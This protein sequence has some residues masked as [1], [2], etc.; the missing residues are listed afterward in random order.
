MPGI[1]QH[2]RRLDITVHQSGRMG[3][4]QSRSHRRHQRHHP[5]RRQRARAAHQR[6]HVPAGHV[7]HCDEQHPIG[8]AG[9]MHRD[10]V[11]VIDRRGRPRLAQEPLPE[12]LISRQCRRQD[13]QRHPPAQPLITR[14]EH[15]RHPT[16]ADL[17]FQPVP[18]HLR[19]RAKP[20]QRAI[21]PTRKI[22][23]RASRGRVPTIPTP[24][25]RP[26]NQHPNTP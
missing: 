15:H 4:V 24:P 11:R 21:S 14:A 25:Q 26:G 1:Q 10:D 5:R 9:L 22:P 18:G 7:P 17:P 13:L 8:F 12:P 16:R 19:T 23:H 6:Q 20:S 3:G 2:V